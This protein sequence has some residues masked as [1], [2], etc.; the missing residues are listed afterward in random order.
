MKKIAFTLTC[1]CLLVLIPLVS[2]IGGKL[3]FQKKKQA[4]LTEVTNGVEVYACGTH[5]ITVR[6]DISV[7]S[8]EEPEHPK[9]FQSS[10][11][12]TLQPGE[13]TIVFYDRPHHKTLG[14]IDSYIILLPITFDITGVLILI[15]IHAFIILII[16]IVNKTKIK[17]GKLDDIETILLVLLTIEICILYIIFMVIRIIWDPIEFTCLLG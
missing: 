12:C 11:F 4:I 14:L 2:S 9:Q 16:I 7:E 3:V 17:K 8:L 5:P 10:Q 6:V 13:K 1:T 15:G